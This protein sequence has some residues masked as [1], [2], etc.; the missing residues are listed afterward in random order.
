MLSTWQKFQFHVL[1]SRHSWNAIRQSRR[2]SSKT[3]GIAK[4]KVTKSKIGNVKAFKGMS[5]EDSA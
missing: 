4:C 5:L 3:P 2:D 1:E